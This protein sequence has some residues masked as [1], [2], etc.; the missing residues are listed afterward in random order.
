MSGVMFNW[1]NDNLYALM[2]CYADKLNTREDVL[3]FVEHA[4]LQYE[5]TSI[6]DLIMTVGGRLSTFPSRVMTSYVDSY[7]RMKQKDSVSPVSRNAYIVWEK[8]KIDV[9]SVWIDKLRKIGIKP[10]IG[11]RLNDAH[12]CFDEDSFLADEMSRQ[13]PEYRRVRH[14]VGDDWQAYNFDFEIEEVRA[15]KLAYIDECL[16]RYDVDGIELDWQ[17][18]LRCFRHGR[19]AIGVHIINDFMRSVKN[20]AKKYEE[21]RGHKISIGVRMPASVETAYNFGFDVLSWLQEDLIDMLVITSRWATTDTDMPVEVW[22]G[23]LA[24]YKNVTL[25]AGIESLMHENPTYPYTKNNFQTVAA[26]AASYYSAGV[27]KIYLF[28]YMSY[29][30]TSLFGYKERD[31]HEKIFKSCADLESSLKAARTHLV[32]YRDVLPVGETESLQVPQLCSAEPDKY[33]EKVFNKFRI[34]TGKVLPG[35]KVKVIIGVEAP[36]E[37]LPGDVTAFLNT[38]PIVFEGRYDE[39]SDYTEKSLYCFDVKA[40]MINNTNVF[41]VAANRISFEIVHIEIKIN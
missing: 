39:K 6:T 37:L 23:I 27:D 14:H 17:R 12:Y 35:S 10:W 24:P 11:V 30:E 25:A 29:D 2:E 3:A 16:E 1:D 21:L 26:C 13:H 8:Y 40:E 4:V 9:F 7:N 19:E 18:E 28:N 32:S 22:K 20:I 36:E 15:Y 38:E 5:N 34:R 41:E 33:F 31:I